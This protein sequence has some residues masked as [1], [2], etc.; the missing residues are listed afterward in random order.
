MDWF[1]I[2][3]YAGAFLGSILL[4]LMI[5][6]VGNQLVP[7][8]GVAEHEEAET[9]G[10]DSG[11]GAEE[12]EPAA[13]EEASAV[14]EEEAPVV[15]EEPPAV[16]E[17]A[18]AV[19][20]VVSAVEEAATVAEE[21]ALVVE[22]AVAAPAAVTPAA[23]AGGPALAALLAAATPEQGL[24]ATKVCRTCHTFENGG[25][26]KI[27]PNLWDI[28]GAKI[29]RDDGFKYSKAFSELSG[30]W[31]YDELFNFLANPKK[32]APGT[33]MTQKVKKSAARAA[34]IMFLRLMSDNP[35][36]LPGGSAE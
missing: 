32:Y 6:V 10:A 19:E 7:T 25:K 11:D 21:E 15:E 31:S 14:E 16:K 27:G 30:E 33:K 13:E 2:N 20:E 22:E 35:L 36:P 28:V 9:L 5:N 26:N 1:Q 3:K 4:L 8:Y 29:A 24:K 12:A 23:P 18:L 34:A 17:V